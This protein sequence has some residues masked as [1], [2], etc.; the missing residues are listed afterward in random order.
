[1]K[2]KQ[3]IMCKRTGNDL[4]GYLKLASLMKTTKTQSALRSN[5]A[6][7]VSCLFAMAVATG[8]ASTKVSDREQLVTGQLPRPAHIWV[9]DFAATAADIPDNSALASSQ[10]QN[11]ASQTPEHIATARRL[12][13]EIATELVK[14]IRA[15][16]M[17]GEYA[18]EG[19]RPQINDIVIKGYLVSF[20]KGDVDKRVGIGLG[21]GSSELKAV[22]EGFQM[23]AQGLRKLGSGE[24]DATGAKTPG[25]AVGLVTLIATHNPAGLIVSTGMKVYGEKSGKATI[26]GRAEQTAK[27]IADVL[28]KRFQEQGWVQ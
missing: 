24:T 10:P 21:E 5:L 22:A 28:E 16:G 7:I 27:E 8:C 25:A 4:Q 11:A 23:T 12:G 15:M 13:A 19:S 26:E 1:M 20:N 2:G 17:P 9:H 18:L 14:Q 6:I 3:S